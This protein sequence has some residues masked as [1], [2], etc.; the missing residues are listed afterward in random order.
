VSTSTAIA[1][2]PTTAESA[3]GDVFAASRG[4]TRIEPRVVERIATQAVREVPRAS[5]TA[6][7]LLGVSVGTAQR[8]AD[9][10]VSADVEGRVAT[11]SVT[12]TVS[13]PSSVREVTRTTRSHI[14]ARV[15]ELADVEVRQVNI[16]VDGMRAQ[17]LPDTRVR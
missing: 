15:L 12:M 10:R 17:G 7:R 2:N 5:G 3:S 14:V 9:A 13:Y 16:T 1:G 4:S 8:P 11:V 6:R